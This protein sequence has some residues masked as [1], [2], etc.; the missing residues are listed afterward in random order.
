MLKS[1]HH[2]GTTNPLR[3]FFHL[4]LPRSCA[5]LDTPAP[6]RVPPLYSK[7][8][9]QCSDSVPFVR[10]HKGLLHLHDDVRGR[11]A[12]SQRSVQQGVRDNCA[13]CCH[14]RINYVLCVYL[15]SVS[16]AH[17]RLLSHL[18]VLVFQLPMTVSQMDS[19]ATIFEPFWDECAEVSCFSCTRPSPIFFLSIS[20]S[21]LSPALLSSCAP[22]R[23]A[24]QHL[25]YTFL[26]PLL[27]CAPDYTNSCPKSQSLEAAGDEGLRGF[28][29]QCMEM[30]Y[31]PGQCGDHCT[32]GTQSQCRCC[33]FDASSSPGSRRFNREKE[34]VSAQLTAPACPRNAALPAGRAE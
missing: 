26:S 31:K 8:L 9:H 19:C 2:S 16:R 23:S 7:L 14:F 12:L 17:C 3:T 24:A 34:L 32:S 33:R 11:P 22:L 6:V 1:P 28:Y 30:L 10:C 27:L 13:R 18:E 25:F 21:P 29:T 5:A 4:S 20:Y 15:E